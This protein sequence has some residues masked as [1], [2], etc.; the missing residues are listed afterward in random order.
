MEADRLKLQNI[1][2]QLS[3]DHLKYNNIYSEVTGIQSNQSIMHGLTSVNRAI[4]K[5]NTRITLLLEI[6][7]YLI[8][9][10]IKTHKSE[11]TLQI[12]PIISS[13]EGPL[14]KNIMASSTNI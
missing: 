6:T 5:I 9:Y 4:Y 1:Y 10:L 12:R 13:L 3:Q 2:N 7:N 8:Y 11:T 14:Y